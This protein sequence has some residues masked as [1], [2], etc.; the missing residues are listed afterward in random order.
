[1]FKS[2]WD[3]FLKTVSNDDNP[4]KR[5]RYMRREQDVC[6]IEINGTTYPI[7]DWSMGGALIETPTRSF[8][9]GQEITF[10]IKFKLRDRVLEVTHKGKVMRTSK[11]QMAIQFD[12]LPGETRTE[13]D[14]VV[15][16]ANA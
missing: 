15:E 14:R 16:D 4:S 8:A 13:F 2:T 6:A 9:E 10:D 1:M 3:K 7:K 12:P 11:T 5:R